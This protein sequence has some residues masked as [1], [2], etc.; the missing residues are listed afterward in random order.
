MA[1]QQRKMVLNRADTGV[2]S[3]QEDCDQLWESFLGAEGTGIISML[4]TIDQYLGLINL[5]DRGIVAVDNEE[6]SRVSRS[7]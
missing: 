6:L 2:P 4:R 5:G 7:F 1:H 3:R